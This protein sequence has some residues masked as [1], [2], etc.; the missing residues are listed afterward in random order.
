MS[1]SKTE[2]KEKR[3]V[4]GAAGSGNPTATSDRLLSGKPPLGL[5]ESSASGRVDSAQGGTS[6]S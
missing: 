2:M 4:N 6:S 5:R 3:I 1:Q